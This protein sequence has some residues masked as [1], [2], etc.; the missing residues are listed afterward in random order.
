MRASFLPRHVSQHTDLFCCS[1]DEDEASHRAR[2]AVRNNNFT[3]QTNALDVDKHMMAYIEE[4]LKIRSQPKEEAPPKPADPQDALYDI[5]D[6]WKW[7]KQ[8]PKEGSVTNSSAML[9]AI[10]EV[11]LGMDT[12]LRNIEDTERA[13]QLIAGSRSEKRKTAEDEEDHLSSSRY[14]RPNL[15]GKSDSEAMRDAKLEAMGL[16]VPEDRP[17]H[18]PNRSQTATDEMVME[19]FKKRMRK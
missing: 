9:T 12:R 17:Q 10:P 4:N 19:R 1:Q 16:P 5:G 7:E 8:Q 14:Y 15:K 11:D 3:G 18:N 2:K 13:K 6:R